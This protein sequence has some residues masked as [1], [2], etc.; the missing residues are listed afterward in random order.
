MN[1]TVITVAVILTLV[2]CGSALPQRQAPK[3]GAVVKA[4]GTLQPEV[5]VDVS[6]VIRGKIQKLLPG[7]DWG[8][9]VKKG[10]VLAEIE[11]AA[12]QADVAIARASVA[13]AEAGSLSAKAQTVQV[14]RDL[15]R[16]KKLLATGGV[17]QAELEKYQAAVE[18]AKA[19]VVV[20]D[21]KT[22]RSKAALARAQLD[23]DAC[24][25][26]SPIDGVIIDRRVNVGQVVSETVSAPSLFLIASDLKKLEVWA[27]VKEADITRVA[28]G[29]A[30]TFTVDAFPKDTFKGRVTQIR[31]NATLSKD[32][33]TYT[34]VIDVDNRDGRLLPYL[35]AEVTIEAGERR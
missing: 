34:V 7:G 17:T 13:E 27:M 14:E 33:V 15:E 6:S 31:L 4:I 18:V 23:L 25:I 22:A 20:T 32:Q 26:R 35:T 3:E 11:S 10:D 8:A 5:V 30:A 28:K 2:A 16:A 12:F 24:S 21:A 29:Q 9:S 1:K 19:K